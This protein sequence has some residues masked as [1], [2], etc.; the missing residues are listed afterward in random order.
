MF[1]KL[2]SKSLS[3]FSFTS[4]L[5]FVEITVLSSCLKVTH[6]ALFFGGALRGTIFC[7]AAK[8]LALKLPCSCG[9]CTANRP[10]KIGHPGCLYMFDSFLF[11]EWMTLPCNVIN[12]CWRCHNWNYSRNSTTHDSTPAHEPNSM[13]C[14]NLNSDEVR[15]SASPQ[16]L[17]LC[18]HSFHGFFLLVPALTA[19][20]WNNRIPLSDVFFFLVVNHLIWW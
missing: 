2:S 12:I 5:T 20:S 3:L 13:P 19:Y 10:E 7:T 4:F 6:F 14:F 15:L 18:W 1:S 17:Y 11:N 9:L 16:I 8:Q